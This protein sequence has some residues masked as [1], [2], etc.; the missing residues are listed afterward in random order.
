MHEAMTPT[1][2]AD[3]S[4]TRTGRTYGHSRTSERTAERRP[5][6]TTGADGDGD[7]D[8]DA[9]A[10]GGAPSGKGL[11]AAVAVT[12]HESTDRH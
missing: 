8:E 4:R 5:S 7:T 11:L 2:A 12:F 10:P 6:A 9:D 3:I 1:S